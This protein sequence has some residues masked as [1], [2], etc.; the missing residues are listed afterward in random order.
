VEHTKLK[1][2]KADPGSQ[3][4]CH[5]LSLC[6]PERCIR[7]QPGFVHCSFTPHHS[8]LDK[9]I[10]I[11][12]PKDDCKSATLARMLSVTVFIVSIWLFLFF[13]CSFRLMFSTTPQGYLLVAACARPYSLSKSSL[14]PTFSASALQKSSHSNSAAPPTVHLMKACL[15]K[16]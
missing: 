16:Y 5:L 13:L 10:N 3:K 9:R 1:E 12:A 15:V 8:A 2:T 6:V 4:Y 14:S 11:S 7:G